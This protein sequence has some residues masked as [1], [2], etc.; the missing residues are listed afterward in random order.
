MTLEKAVALA[1]FRR[2]L[3]GATMPADLVAEATAADLMAARRDLADFLEC[4]V[5]GQGW[6]RHTQSGRGELFQQWKVATPERRSGK[7]GAPKQSI[8]E[9]PVLM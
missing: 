2:L 5:S 3:D 9:G 8:R 7:W 6:N 4:L 1:A